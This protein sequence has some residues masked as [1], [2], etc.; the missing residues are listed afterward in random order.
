MRLFNIFSGK[1][2]ADFERKGDALARDQA[3]GEAKLAFEAGLDKI[4]KESSAD[5]AMGNRPME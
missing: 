5:S 4:A 1:S 3:W 2:P